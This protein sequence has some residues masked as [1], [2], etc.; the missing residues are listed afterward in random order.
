[1]LFEFVKGNEFVEFIT[2]SVGSLLI[3]TLDFKE[4]IEEIEELIKIGK[5]TKKAFAHGKANQYNV[6]ILGQDPYKYDFSIRDIEELLKWAESES[7][8]EYT[9]D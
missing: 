7:E 2:P 1:M 4:E 9:N 5:A 6:L 3:K 8:G